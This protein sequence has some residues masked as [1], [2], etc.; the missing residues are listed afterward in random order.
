MI[1]RHNTSAKG[2]RTKGTR[3][4]GRGE[5]RAD[6]PLVVPPPVEPV[7]VDVV[8][9]IERLAPPRYRTEREELF[10]AL[11]DDLG[12]AAA[13]RDDATPD[14]TFESILFLIPFASPRS[15]TVVPS[16]PAAS[17]PLLQP[18]N[19]WRE[20]RKLE[21]CHEAYIEGLRDHPLVRSFPL[22]DL[23]FFPPDELRCPHGRLRKRCQAIRSLLDLGKRRPFS[24][25]SASRTRLLKELWRYR[26]RPDADPT[27]YCLPISRERLADVPPLP[28]R[29]G[30]P[31]DEPQRELLDHVGPL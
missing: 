23:A 1:R 11:R 29:R 5:H 10:R 25:K 15:H 12:R 22:N 21:A 8:T 24:E 6:D 3:K 7:H 13:G 18:H 19:Y 28:A 4:Q 17:S 31:R 9:A 2:P 20:R 30:R 14:E 16:S 26:V 27:A